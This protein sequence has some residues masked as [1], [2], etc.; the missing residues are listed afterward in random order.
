MDIDM[1]DDP[2]PSDPT[3]PLRFPADA[4]GDE[5]PENGRFTVRSEWSMVRVPKKRWFR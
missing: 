5:A 2:D 4:D 1:I 3:D